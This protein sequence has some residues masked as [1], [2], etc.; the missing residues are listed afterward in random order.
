VSH[1]ICRRCFQDFFQGHFDFMKSLPVL[2]VRR[3]SRVRSMARRSARQQDT[4]LAQP[5]LFA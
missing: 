5:S 2:E 4:L 1:G 3:R